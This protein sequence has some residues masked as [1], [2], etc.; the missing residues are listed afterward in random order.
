MKIV[1]A[2]LPQKSI[3][4]LMLF[5]LCNT[6]SFYAQF[7][8]SPNGNDKNA[9]TES[10][11]FGSINGALDNIARM[12]KGNRV[13]R[14][15]DIIL[16]SGTYYLA[17]P[18]LITPNNWD[19]NGKLTI[20]GE[21]NNTPV[22]KGSIRL[23]QFER[24]SDRLW[25]MDISQ[26]IRKNNLEVQQLFINGQ[27]AVRAR[28][29]NKGNLFKTG[30]VTEKPIRGATKSVLKEISM[31]N[32]QMNALKSASK[33][34][35]NVVIS[36]NHKWDRTRGYIDNI[37]TRNNKINFIAE[38]V[39]P[40]LDL[41]SDSQF[42]FENSI[43]FL[44]EPGEWFLDADG[45]LY[46]IPKENETI[47]TTVAE[48]PVIDKLLQISGITDKTVQNISFRNISFQHTKYTMPKK[49]EK[50]QQAASNTSASITLDFAQNIVFEAC[51][52]ANISNNAVWM[53]TG[54][55]DN[56]I[57]HCYIHDMGI[58]GIKIG[59]IRP[60]ITSAYTTERIIVYNN[61]IHNGGYEI[62]TGV[63]IT[64]F[65]SGNNMITHNDIGNFKY[66]GVSVGWIWGYG[67]SVSKNNKIE[68][69]HIH[70][71]G[72]G[73]LSDMGGVY[74]LGPSEGTVINNN[75]IH[76]IYSY[77][78]GGWG[79]Y[80]DEGSTGVLIKNNLVYNCKSS[81]FHQH[82]GKENIIR[83]NI[84]A[85][86]IKA[87]LEATLREDHLSFSFTNNIVY[88]SRGV[89]I[90]KKGWE[91]ININSDRNIYWDT[92]TRN[93]HF[94]DFSFENWKK[95]TKKDKNSIIA[96]PLFREPGNYDFRFRSGQNIEKINF[97]PFDY[98]QAGVYGS[99]EWKK[100]AVLDPEI[101][102]AFNKSIERRMKEEGISK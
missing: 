8:I 75:V 86:Q 84:F 90:G 39:P 46:Y 82:Y 9:G 100:K 11:P 19:G 28:T 20:R 15:V 25:K 49:G 66:S 3:I 78:Y 101:I 26:T 69:N 47:A 24:V 73:E 77:D 65:H 31:T 74:T 30:N 50:P 7:Y 17:E 14:D 102:K 70:H 6:G 22:L 38:T 76:D 33:D 34:I 98:S 89:L 57:I 81:G 56:R 58:G 60:P 59:D 63:G 44:D 62:P 10:L 45:I 53:K 27:R 12:R 52:I 32:E 37:S 93:I 95:I 18:I 92:R 41:A 2:G 29:P 87:Q 61:I 4:F 40:W 99:V 1:I 51:E 42:F 5:L 16:K 23:Q 88:F 79:L 97:T 71:L 48:V 83:N 21:D 35:R 96:D 68:F 64:I 80:T 55:I 13:K 67:R 72:W 91:V 54:C 43:A 36:F 94:L 85:N